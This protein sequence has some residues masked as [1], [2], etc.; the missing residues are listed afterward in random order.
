MVNRYESLGAQGS[1][2][3]CVGACA[4]PGGDA[5]AFRKP[6]AFA[7][8][9]DLLSMNRNL[10]LE[11][12]A[13]SLQFADGSVDFIFTNVLDH[14]PDLYRFASEVA[15]VLKGGRL[16]C[17]RGAAPALRQQDAFAVR[18]SGTEEACAA[19]GLFMLGILHALGA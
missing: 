11:G 2:V 18:P 10:V 15:R 17:G 16:L 8:G 1:S 13:H 3:L 12:D 4:Q 14:I 5:R 19:V 7:V 9:T 6:G